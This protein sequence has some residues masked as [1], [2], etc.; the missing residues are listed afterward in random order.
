M[1]REGGKEAKPR[2]IKIYF[3]FLKRNRTQLPCLFG[4]PC[5]RAPRLPWTPPGRAGL[6]V[7]PGGPPRRE[8]AGTVQ[9]HGEASAVGGMGSS[10]PSACGAWGGEG[11][12]RPDTSVVFLLQNPGLAGL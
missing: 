10:R 11:G 7:L 8:W 5:R 2:T 12:D 6:A 9:Q 1:V 3:F 4:E